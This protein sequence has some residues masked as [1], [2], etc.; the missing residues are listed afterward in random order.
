MSPS[1]ASRWDAEMSGSLSPPPVH[2]EPKPRPRRIAMPL[3]LLGV[4]LVAV[5][6]FACG[7]V[8]GLLVAT[9]SSGTL[10]QVQIEGDDARTR[11]AE[12]TTELAALRMELRDVQADVEEWRKDARGD[13]DPELTEMQ[14]RA[15]YG[16]PSRG[17]ADAKWRVLKTWR[18]GGTK[19]T[20]SFDVS[21]PLCRI[22][23]K[24]ARYTSVDVR[25]AQ[26]ETIGRAYGSFIGQEMMRVSPGRYY[27]VIRSIGSAQVTIEEPE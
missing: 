25:N 13:A 3:E 4:L 26:G 9:L 22:S 20:E 14:I 16:V 7:L 8:A 24:S 18:V 5:L 19:T 12:A 23:W 1:S 10:G 15:M 11:L 2:E 6:A 27:L 21:M 17:D